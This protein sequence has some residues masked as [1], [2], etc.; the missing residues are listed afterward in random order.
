MNPPKTLIPIEISWDGPYRV[1]ECVDS[2]ASDSDRGLYQII[3]RHD[4]YSS[5]PQDALLY[6]GSTHRTFS[7]RMTEHRDKRMV[8]EKE[9]YV[10]VGRLCGTEQP[11]EED[12]VKIIDIAEKLLIFAHQPAWNT[13]E[14]SE[15]TVDGD[16]LV[17]N[18]GQRGRGWVLPEVSSLY[19]KAPE[20]VPGWKI[21]GN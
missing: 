7:R 21:F 19:W 2:L 8:Q 10:Y 6:I 1:S 4:V 18:W 9:H 13:K 5:G 15:F 17:L 20:E 3:G 11:A 16:Y 14:K 12:L